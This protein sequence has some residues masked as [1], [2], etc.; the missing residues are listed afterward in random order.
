MADTTKQVSMLELELEDDL[1]RQIEDVADSSCFSKDELLQSILEA[2]RHH[3]AYIHRLENMVQ[4][5]NIK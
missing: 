5:I 2:W 1:I 4:I 3:Q